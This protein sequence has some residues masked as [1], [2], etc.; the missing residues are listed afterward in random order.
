MMTLP[1]QAGAGFEFHPDIVMPVTT[2]PRPE[3]ADDPAVPSGVQH[4]TGAL[5]FKFAFYA[6]LPIGL[7]DE[8]ALAFTT[9]AGG[10]IENNAFL[11]DGALALGNASWVYPVAE[12]G[13]AE[14][15]RHRFPA[16]FTQDGTE[17]AMFA[18][19][20]GTG[21]NHGELRYPASWSGL[22]IG[23][24]ELTAAE[25]DL[26]A[27]YS[28]DAIHGRTN[29]ALIGPLDTQARRP[30]HLGSGPGTFRVGRYLNGSPSPHRLDFYWQRHANID[31]T[32]WGSPLQAPV[33]GVFA[34]AAPRSSQERLRTL[35]RLATSPIDYAIAGE[36]PR[37]PG[38]PDFNGNLVPATP[39]VDGGVDGAMPD[40]P[41]PDG[42]PPDGPPVDGPPL[43]AP[44][45]DAPFVD[46]GIDG[47][48][49]DSPAPPDAG[50]DAELDAGPDAD[51]GSDA[52]ADA[53]TDAVIE[54]PGPG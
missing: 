13:L 15:A 33:D 30:T 32:Y 27:S 34:P 38:K 41:P 35:V 2:V 1:E 40:G 20:R 7:R 50:T 36:S 39:A 12:E 54:G 25:L 3:Y 6:S 17:V 46:A 53:V 52:D 9:S 47:A 19:G 23:A 4:Q 5:W 42:S 44:M 11:R 10:S 49:V 43:D 31:E 28:L 26:D 18:V 45:I 16:F 29:P 21:A 22:R 8:P 48:P 51:A 37:P 14:A 24:L